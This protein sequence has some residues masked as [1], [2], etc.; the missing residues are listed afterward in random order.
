VDWTFLGLY[1]PTWVL[2]SLVV[3][4]TWGLAVNWLGRK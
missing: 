3:V 4:G 2:I 1:M